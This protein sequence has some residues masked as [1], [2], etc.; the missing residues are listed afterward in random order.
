MWWSILG[1]MMTKSLDRLLPQPWG[2][3]YSN[4][5]PLIKGKIWIVFQTTPHTQQHTW[6]LY[7][8]TPHYT[9]STVLQPPWRYVTLHTCPILSP[10]PARCLYLVAAANNRSVE[11][12]PPPPAPPLTALQVAIP[13]HAAMRSRTSSHSILTT[14]LLLHLKSRFTATFRIKEIPEFKLFLRKILQRQILERGGGI[15]TSHGSLSNPTPQPPTSHTHPTRTTPTPT[16]SPY[17][18]STRYCWNILI[19]QSIVI[20]HRIFQRKAEFWEFYVLY[21]RY[22]WHKILHVRCILH[23]TYY[24][25]ISYSI[26]HTHFI[27]YLHVAYHKSF[28]HHILRVLFMS[29]HISISQDIM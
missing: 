24:I 13:Y 7:S 6:H 5:L 12:P 3:H 28:S 9:S 29:Y 8:H 20:C 16:S 10:P 17:R 26:L 14:L 23:I 18:H 15:G 11:S 4:Y 27:S 2:C 1:Y 25:Y 19:R 21:Y 22:I